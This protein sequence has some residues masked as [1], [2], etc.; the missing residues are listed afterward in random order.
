MGQI[1]TKTG[2]SRRKNWPIGNRP[3]VRVG[4]APQ[5]RLAMQ[6]RKKAVSARAL[7]AQVRVKGRHRNCP[8]WCGGKLSL[9]SDSTGQGINVDEAY[10]PVWIM[11]ELTTERMATELAE[12]GYYM[13]DALIEPYA[14]EP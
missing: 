2:K 6:A 4:R 12:A 7:L 9:P 10:D 11:G 13:A 8:P 1:P 3:P 14:E 5:V